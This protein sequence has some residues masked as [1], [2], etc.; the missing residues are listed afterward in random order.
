MAVS[1]DAPAD[2]K[3]VVEHNHL[4][5]DILSDE[6][7]KVVTQLGLLHHEK[8]QKK[9]ISLPANF[10]IDKSGKIVWRRVAGYVQDR[11]DPAEVREEVRKLP[12]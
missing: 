8:M 7:A 1:V 5:F 9:D 12:A 4:P 6:G 11:P 3:R 2:S 10:L